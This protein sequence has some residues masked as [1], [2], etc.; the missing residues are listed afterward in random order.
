MKS[1]TIREIFWLL[2]VVSHF[3]FVST[4][5]RSH[6]SLGFQSSGSPGWYMHMYKQNYSLTGTLACSSSN[7]LLFMVTDFLTNSDDSLTAILS[8]K[9]TVSS[10]KL[11]NKHI[12]HIY[13]Y[14]YWEGYDKKVKDLHPD[15]LTYY[16]SP[17]Q[18]Y[19]IFLYYYFQVN[20]VAFNS[21]YKWFSQV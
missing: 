15:M 7:W 13:I 3:S 5:K 6:F 4:W 2:P 20:C 17:F 10:L 16:F 19:S 14:I 1:G 18:S 21:M 11:Q 8:I 9:L 12:H